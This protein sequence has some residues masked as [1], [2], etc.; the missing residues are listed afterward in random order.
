MRADMSSNPELDQTKQALQPPRQTRQRGNRRRMTTTAAVVDR[1]TLVTAAGNRGLRAPRS[2]G[3]S[4]ITYV[5]PR[6]GLPRKAP[7][8]A[9]SPRRAAPLPWLGYNSYGK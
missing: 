1:Q 2:R 6:V 7:I 9:S 5:L 3:V 8:R 4:T